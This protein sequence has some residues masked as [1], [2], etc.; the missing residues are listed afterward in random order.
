[1]RSSPP[2]QIGELRLISKAS[3]KRGNASG[4]LWLSQFQR[5]ALL[6]RSSMLELGMHQFRNQV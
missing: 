4:G 1:M 2:A 5:V 6:V 3:R